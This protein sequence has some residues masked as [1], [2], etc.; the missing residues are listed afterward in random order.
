L[1]HW[2][3]TTSTHDNSLPPP[4][5][6]SPAINDE[7]FLISFIPLPE[8]A[9]VCSENV[10]GATIEGATRRYT[11]EITY[12]GDITPKM[13]WKDRINNID[14]IIDESDP[15]AD[16]VK[17]SIDVAGSQ[18]SNGEMYECLTYFSPP[19]SPGDDFHPDAPTY[20]SN[21]EPD[22]NEVNCKSCCMS[23][24]QSRVVFG[25]LCVSDYQLLKKSH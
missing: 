15:D 7:W 10:T 18:D 19:E 13:Q 17:T 8:G 14:D 20:T 24:V 22:A 16:L 6:S 12:K 23:N 11:C 21:Y 4:P 9:P 25:Y 3:F 5:H 1:G 2:N